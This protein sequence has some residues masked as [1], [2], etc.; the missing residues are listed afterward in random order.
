MNQIVNPSATLSLLIH[1]RVRGRGPV[2]INLPISSVLPFETYQTLVTLLVKSP[3]M[4]V[5]TELPE[6]LINELSE[7][8]IFVSP[9]EA[10]APMPH[11][12]CQLSHELPS[13]LPA[14][15][16]QNDTSP[17]ELVLAEDLV[18]EAVS[19]QALPEELPFA[20]ELSPTPANLWVHDLGS[21]TWMPYHLGREIQDEAL[22][23][24]KKR[25]RV[26]NLPQET[27]RVLRLAGVLFPKGEQK[28]RQKE[29]RQILK[30]AKQH[31]DENE[32]A[33]IRGFLNPLQLAEVR[34]YYRALYQTGSFTLG[35]PHVEL[36]DWIYNE[37]VACFLHHQILWSVNQLVPEEVKPSY[38]YLAVYRPGAILSRHVDRPQCQWNVSLVLDTDPELQVTS[39]W[40]LYLEVRGEPHAVRLAMGDYVLFR[41]THTPHWREAQPAGH[42]STVCFF[43][44]VSKDFEGSLA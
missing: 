32:F 4:P 2:E 41:G 16:I 30:D 11:F 31:L 29:W 6:E 23:V 37:P 21:N 10:V 24:L 43:H 22:H 7:A 33:V 12:E 26:N 19:A 15:S 18:C 39:S 20:E 35:D 28:A 8:G 27:A 40:P 44:F 9:E 5:P 38:A 1:C 14:D 13:L 36:R 3:G 42:S 25:T 17:R 34:R